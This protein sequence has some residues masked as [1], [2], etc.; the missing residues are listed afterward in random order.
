VI[1]RREPVCTC[2]HVLTSHSRRRLLCI[3][4]PRC[5]CTGWTPAARP[6][7]RSCGCGT[8]PRPSG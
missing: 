7:L 4:H 1:A 8:A 2:H 3:A 5:G 6:A